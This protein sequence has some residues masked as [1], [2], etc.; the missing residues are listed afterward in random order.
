M[1]DR[2]FLTMSLTIIRH[3]LIPQCNKVWK[4]HD[5]RITRRVVEPLSW[6]CFDNILHGEGDWMKLR[7]AVGMEDIK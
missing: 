2:N 7:D 3:F 1:A 6:Q 4:Q 5:V